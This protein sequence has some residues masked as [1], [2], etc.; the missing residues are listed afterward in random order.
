LPTNDT[1]WLAWE[2]RML[3][4]LRF[5][6]GLCFVEHGTSKLFA[7]P[8]AA[9]FAHLHLASLIGVQGFI[10][11]IGGSLICLGLFTRIVGFILS[12]DMAVAY[13]MVHFQKSYFP[14]L[15]GGDAAILYCFIFF[16][17]FVAGGGAWSLDRLLMPRPARVS[18]AARV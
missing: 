8:P 18:T 17:L 4:V 1:W 16:Y 3:S 11:L 15:S 7:V 10:E 13:F 5:V 2:P 6:A 12:G 9:M 14:A